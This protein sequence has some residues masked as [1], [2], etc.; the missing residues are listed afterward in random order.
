MFMTTG[1]LGFIPQKRFDNQKLIFSTP[2]TG[3]NVTV[4]IDV[5]K[6]LVKAWGAGGGGGGGMPTAGG[7][8]GAG[9]F[10]SSEFTVVPGEQLVVRVAGGGQ[11]PTNITLASQ[12][13][14]LGGINGGGTGG[15][16]V[17]S[18]DS[19]ATGGG[20][21][22]G[23]SGV[24]RQGIPL[25]IAAGG[26][27]GGGGD[28]DVTINGAGNGGPGGFLDGIDGDF[29]QTIS[30]TQ[31]GAGGKGGTQTAGGAAGTASSQSISPIP[32]TF[33][34]GGAG[35]TGTQWRAGGGGGGGGYW[36]GGGASAGYAGNCSGSGGGGGSSYSI[37]TIVI[38]EN[39]V[40]NN[41]VNTSDPDY[42]T[43]VSSG[44]IGGP[45]TLNKR[46]ITA[47][48][49]GGDGLVIIEFFSV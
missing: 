7:N 1:L 28:D 22:G 27:G 20:G 29:A 19:D 10:I 40:A 4:P 13:G 38:F 6:M 47:G 42:I 35:G 16:G 34:Q 33:L 43:G 32:G 14:G 5:R 37:N 12:P 44:G 26:G 18:G 46:D 8:G 21:G 30:G 2:T 24:F 25:I 3:V 11:A 48:L 49:P 9:S 45:S 36:G 41:P 15:D 31:T 17:E 23:Y 39:G